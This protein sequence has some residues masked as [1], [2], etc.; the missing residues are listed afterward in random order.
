[1]DY[2]LLTGIHNLDKGNS[3]KLRDNMLSVFQVRPRVHRHPSIVCDV[4]TRLCCSPH[5]V[6]GERRRCVKRA[7]RPSWTSRRQQTTRT[8]G[9]SG[10]TRTKAAC[11]R[12]TARTRSC[13]RSIISCVASQWPCA[14]TLNSISQG[15]IDIL[16]PYTFLKRLEHFWRG[17]REDKVRTARAR[18]DRR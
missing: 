13:L 3:D 17:L 11:E 16:T 14:L 6:G 9:S 4:H 15:I 8:G 10:S 1:M 12:P 5:C 2:S 7:S 18:V